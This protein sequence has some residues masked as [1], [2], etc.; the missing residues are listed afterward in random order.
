MRFD[1]QKTFIIVGFLVLLSCQV[2]WAWTKRGHEIVSTVAARVVEEKRDATYLRSREFDLGY[3]GNAPDL[4]WRFDPPPI[5]KVEPP[6]H[7]MDWVKDFQDIFGSPKSLPVEFKDFK[8]KLGDK[9]NIKL[10]VVP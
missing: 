4:I 9:F 8:A 5:S 10:G 6:Q 7:Y 3:Y 1:R 2:S